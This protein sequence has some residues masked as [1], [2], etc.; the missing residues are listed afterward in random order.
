MYIGWFSALFF[1]ALFQNTAATQ[2]K[3][4]LEGYNITFQ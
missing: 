1:I 3:S 2:F 4:P